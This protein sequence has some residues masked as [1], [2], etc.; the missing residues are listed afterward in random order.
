MGTDRLLGD[1]PAS[2]YVGRAL[3]SIVV[4]AGSQKGCLGEIFRNNP[5]PP[6]SI[7]RVSLKQVLY[8]MVP[9][10]KC[11]VLLKG[12]IFVSASG[13]PRWVFFSVV[14]I[15]REEDES[16]RLLAPAS[17][18]ASPPPEAGASV[19]QPSTLALGAPL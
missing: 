1:S 16:A 12:H 13:V 2:T 8:S 11:D 14:D 10:R 19:D 3:G 5:P 6:L 9:G 18:T 17:A 7:Q 15:V 4:E